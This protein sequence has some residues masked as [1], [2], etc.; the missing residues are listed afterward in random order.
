[1]PW[2]ANAR[3]RAAIAAAAAMLSRKTVTAASGT[4]P[5]QSAQASATPWQSSS[6]AIFMSRSPVLAGASIVFAREQHEVEVIGCHQRDHHDDD[7]E[8]DVGHEAEKDSQEGDQSDNSGDA[9]DPRSEEHTTGLQ[10]LLRTSYAVLHLNK[11]KQDK[12]R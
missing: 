3:S 1:M 10:A 11:Q 4:M 8:V 2:A 7:D 9:D 6:N 5:G 12:Q